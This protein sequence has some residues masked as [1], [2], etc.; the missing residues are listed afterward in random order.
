MKTETIPFLANNPFYTERFGQYVGE[1]CRSASIQSVA[2]EYMRAQLERA[3]PE[4]P[5]AIGVDETSI[6]K[7]HTYRIVVSDLDRGCAIWFGGDGRKE[8]DMAKFYDTIGKQASSKIEVAVMDMWKPFRNALKAH[9]PQA[10][11]VFDKFHIMSHLG[12]AMDAVRKA[13]YA[14][15]SGEDRRYIKGQKHT[16]LSHRENLSLEGR[17]AL[18]QL[19]AAN[20]RL[21]TAYLLKEQFGQLWS[22]RTPAGAR[23]F[24][25]RWREALK[26]QR[27]KPYEAFAEMIERQRRHSIG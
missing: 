2:M 25:A 21:N 19:L 9:A 20:K 13:E 4:T 27:L 14:R 24:F 23:K 3:G 8:V 10:Q 5:R 12:K 7:G 18:K 15:L 1:R 6:R 22:Y 26:W 17:K 11:I 16:L